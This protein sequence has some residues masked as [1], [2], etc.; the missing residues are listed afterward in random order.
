MGLASA[1]AQLPHDSGTE[2][3]LR[4]LL[5]LL[6][7]RG[8]LGLTA[9]DIDRV[10]AFPGRDTAAILP[11]LEGAHVVEHDGDPPRYHLT[12]D[13]LVKCEVAEFVRRAQAHAS[14]RRDNVQRFM[15][16]RNRF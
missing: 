13:V 14:Y 6:V 2:R 7:G 5:A 16:R 12:T 3:R 4:E 8:R 10:V 11:V 1:I 15:E 9:E